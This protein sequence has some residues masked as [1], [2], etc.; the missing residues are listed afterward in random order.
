MIALRQLGRQL[1]NLPMQFLY[2]ALAF[3]LHLLGGSPLI[4]NLVLELSDLVP[5]RLH[6]TL[7]LSEVCLAVT[8]LL[9][10]LLKLL[11][12][13]GFLRLEGAS[14]AAQRALQPPGSLIALAA[15]LILHHGFLLKAL[16]FGLKMQDGL[17]ALG[18]VFVLARRLL[19]VCAPQL[20]DLAFL[21]QQLLVALGQLPVLLF[22]TDLCQLQLLLLLHHLLILLFDH[23]LLQIRLRELNRL[24]QVCRLP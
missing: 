10:L 1:L 7:L 6:F 20:V 24:N 23:P 16:H 11:F 13:F 17:V 15:P 2:Q 8:S 5:Q 22:E 4:E 19:F 9:R 12:T 18:E 3:V 21:L 14:L